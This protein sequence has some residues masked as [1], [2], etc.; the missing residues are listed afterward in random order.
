[1]FLKLG[2]Q[3]RAYYSLLCSYFSYLGHAFCESVSS[4]NRAGNRGKMPVRQVEN[5]GR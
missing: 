2:A 1:V 4:R 3:F 5:D